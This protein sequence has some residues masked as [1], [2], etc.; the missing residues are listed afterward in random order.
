MNFLIVGLGNIGEEYAHTKHNI[1]FDILDDLAQ[2]SDIRFKTDR[3]GDV[4]ELRVK[5]HVLTLLKPSTYMNLSGHAVRYWMQ[6]KKIPLENVLVLVDDLALP[7]GQLRL[8]P[9]G[10]DAGH[11]G[12]KHIIQTLGTNVYARLRFGIGNDYPKGHQIDYVLSGWSVEQL[13]TLPERLTMAG[14]IIKSF[15]LA[16]IQRTMNLYNK[17]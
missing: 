11:N 8:R 10:S 16:G 9:G 3:Y 13:E 6:N 14:E 15:C 5:N 17:R 1:G 12:L 4:A 2:D 7:F